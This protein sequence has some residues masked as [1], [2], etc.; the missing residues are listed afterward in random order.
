MSL[1]HE[2]I[3][4]RPDDAV[5]QTAVSGLPSV[6]VCLWPAIPSDSV[7]CGWV[8]AII[9]PGQFVSVGAISHKRGRD[10]SIHA[11]RTLIL[12]P[13]PFAKKRLTR[14]ADCPHHAFAGWLN[15]TILPK[16][17]ILPTSPVR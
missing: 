6:S 16:R 9:K 10:P 15:L 8:I 11:L 7:T 1:R 3:L 5:K 14:L 12:A 17:V 13:Q 4:I 2:S